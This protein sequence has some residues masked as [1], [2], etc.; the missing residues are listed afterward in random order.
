MATRE[1][2]FSTT[3]HKFHDKKPSETNVDHKVKSPQNLDVRL[4]PPNPG[5]VVFDVRAGGLT[6]PI[7]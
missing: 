7:F 2:A 6:P 1:V 4:L 5:R 3:D